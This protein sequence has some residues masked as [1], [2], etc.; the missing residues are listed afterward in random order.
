M[1]TWIKYNNMRLCWKNGSIKIGNI[2]K[3]KQEVHH[4]MFPGEDVLKEL[5]IFFY[6]NQNLF[7]KKNQQI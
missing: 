6:G 3:H 5:L 4:R 7:K 1:W 2:Q